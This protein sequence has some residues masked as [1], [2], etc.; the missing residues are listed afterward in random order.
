M[1]VLEL[2]QVK[3]PNCGA[4][5]T[6]FNAFRAEVE[7]PYCHQKAFNP[8]I[9]SKSVPIPERLIVF[10]TSEED[11]SKKLVSL[12]VDKDFVPTDIFDCINPGNVIK[13][14]LPMYL[15]E[16]KYQASWS[17]SVGYNTT[18]LRASPDGS[19]VN[20][21]T[22][23]KYQFA[24][25]T[26]NGN[27][28]FLCLA[29]EGD[30]VP[31]ELKRFTFTFPYSVRDSKEYDPAL[32]GLDNDKELKTLALNVDAELVW[33][34]HGDGLVN[35]LAKESAR[36][37]V[38]GQ[39]IK[40]F[41]VSSSYDLNTKGRYVLVPF[42]FVYYLYKG[43]KHYFLMDGLGEHHSISAPI[44][45]AEYNEVKK[46]NRIKMW[47]GLGWIIPVLILFAVDT[48]VALFIMAIC[49][50]VAGV[51]Y[52][53]INKKNTSILSTSRMRRKL[54]AKRLLGQNA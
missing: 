45:Q 33:D 14:Y 4:N 40:D 29:Y 12:L 44:N 19:K 9:T 35:D 26:S 18:E 42:W 11:F 31:K 3:C 5:I 41:K 25:G 2:Q 48:L 15:Y 52:S 54:G 34:N 17:C 36:N 23:K 47:A 10:K 46:N 6:S 51:V 43:E 20:N 1:S 39:D 28:S 21:R 50:I 53:K 27:F 7:C 49:M 16:G 30:D 13:A 8:L 37:Q 32:L 22:V 38:K 24:S